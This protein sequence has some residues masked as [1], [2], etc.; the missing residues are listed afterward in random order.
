ME[1]APA[2]TICHDSMKGGAG[3]VHKAFGLAMR[4]A[5]LGADSTS[6]LNAALTKLAADHTNSDGEPT[7]DIEELINGDDPNTVGGEACIG[8]KYGCGASTITRSASK[9]GLDPAATV[10]G[11]LIAGLGLLLLRRRR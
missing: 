5:G 6:Q 2:C 9:R 3:T 4:T 1:C 10:A 11:S 7:P 8:P